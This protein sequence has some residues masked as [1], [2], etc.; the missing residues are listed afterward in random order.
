MS[1]WTLLGF[2]GDPC[3]RDRKVSRHRDMA[4][5]R[6]QSLVMA[7]RSVT[8]IHRSWDKFPGARVPGTPLG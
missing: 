8:T 2:Y 1:D 7:S 4:K 6:G 3:S 5:A